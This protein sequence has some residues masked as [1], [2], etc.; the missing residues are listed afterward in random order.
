[1]AKKGKKGRPDLSDFVSTT[2]VRERPSERTPDNPMLKV[3]TPM[4][5]VDANPS[6]AGKGEQQQSP[7]RHEVREP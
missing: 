5:F 6:A 3:R 2:L 1:M 4:V 7:V